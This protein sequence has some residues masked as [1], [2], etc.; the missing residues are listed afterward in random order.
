MSEFPVAIEAHWSPKWPP[1]DSFESLE[2]AEAWEHELCR[3]LEIPAFEYC[4]FCKKAAWERR[5]AVGRMMIEEPENAYTLLRGYMMLIGDSRPWWKVPSQS[6]HAA[7]PS[8]VK[9]AISDVAKKCGI[10]PRK[11]A[12]L[13]D[14]NDFPKTRALIL[15]LA[16]D[17]FRRGLR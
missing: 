5:E 1:L 6:D 13:L 14:E 15:S 10:A 8:A 2:A 7:W 11:L 9:S 12:Q 16:L 4:Y 3:K 17:L